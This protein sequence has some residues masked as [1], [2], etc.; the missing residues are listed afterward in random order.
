MK[1]ISSRFIITFITFIIGIIG[2]FVIYRF[3]NISQINDKHNNIIPQIKFNIKE[4]KQ[5]LKDANNS[6]DNWQESEIIRGYYENDNYCPFSVSFPNNLIGIFNAPPS[7]PNHG[8]FIPLKSKTE[9]ITNGQVAYDKGHF[10]SIFVAYNSEAL[11]NEKVSVKTIFEKYAIDFL[12]GLKEYNSIDA[13][14]ISINNYK[15]L[16]HPAKRVICEYTSKTT[17]QKMV[18]DE[19]LILGQTYS[20]EVTCD[21]SITL[22]TTKTDYNKELVPYLYIVNSWHEIDE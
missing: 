9:L 8:C 4:N 6:K 20:H 2:T 11:E 7:W 1:W 3:N 18:Y 17:G 13:T 22:V 16:A 12:A 21:F 19:I 10:I 5:A 14:L 15:I